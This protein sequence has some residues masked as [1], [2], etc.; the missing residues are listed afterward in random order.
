ML[1]CLRI[2][3]FIYLQNICVTKYIT[4]IAL[5]LLQV[6]YRQN[7]NLVILTDICTNWY[8]NIYS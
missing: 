7:N 6:S 2:I 4:L 1:Y 8:E 3:I 5:Q